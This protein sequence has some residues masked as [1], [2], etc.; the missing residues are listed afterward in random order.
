MTCPI[1]SQTRVTVHARAQGRCESCGERG[2]LDL[3]H[4]RRVR[5]MVDH[6]DLGGEPVA[7]REE[8]DDLIALCRECHFADHRDPNG[9]YWYDVEE[10]RQFW[11]G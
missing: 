8:P 7:G 1:P 11:S 4:L 9:D 2:P 5:P 3:H 6:H 10:K